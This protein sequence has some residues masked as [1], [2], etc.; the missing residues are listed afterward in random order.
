MDERWVHDQGEAHHPVGGQRRGLQVSTD[1]LHEGI[2]VTATGDP[3]DQ[4]RRDLLLYEE[5]CDLRGHD[6]T[7]RIVVDQMNPV[8]RVGLAVLEV[9]QR[10]DGQRITLQYV[11]WPRWYSRPLA[12]EDDKELADSQGQRDAVFGPHHNWLVGVP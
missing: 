3:S 5:G 6:L 9:E 4:R 12:W 7:Q 2:A 10:R 1:A 8:G 11:D